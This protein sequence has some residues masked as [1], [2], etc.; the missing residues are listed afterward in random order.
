MGP[1]RSV[2]VCPPLIA[3]AMAVA[4]CEDVR[5]D[6]FPLAEGNV[7]EYR[8]VSKDPAAAG[9]A[10]P[11][12]ARIE[13]GPPLRPLTYRASYKDNG[14]IWSKEDGFVNLQDAAGR[15]YLLRL[16]PHTGYKWIEQD[17]SGNARYFEIERHED[18]VTPAG[19]F[20]GC[21]KVVEED[22]RRRDRICYWFA[23]DVGLVRRARYSQGIEVFRCELVSFDLKAPPAKPPVEAGAKTRNP[24]APREGPYAAPPF[25]QKGRKTNP[26]SWTSPGK[27]SWGDE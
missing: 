22:R 6:Y 20:R 7:W 3:L 19:A 8:L 10:R 26:E 13:I 23:P 9:D 16:P 2:R 14:Q 1:E 17:P 12:T 15:H 27:N 11:E 21:A 18:V 4:G 25:W 5:H 24:A